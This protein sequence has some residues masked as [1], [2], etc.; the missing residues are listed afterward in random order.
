MRENH[1]ISRQQGLQQDSNMSDNNDYHPDRYDDVD[2]VYRWAA[3]NPYSPLHLQHLRQPVPRDAPRGLGDQFTFRDAFEDLLITGSG[4]ALPDAREVARVK[5]LE[6]SYHG[7]GPVVGSWLGGLVVGLGAGGGT[8]R[9][10]GFGDTGG[11]EVHV[12]TW[13]Q[14]LG[15]LGLWGSFFNL[16]P[17]IRDVNVNARANAMRVW[18]PSRFTA[19]ELMMNPFD[20][21]YYF[22]CRHHAHAGPHRP[23]PFWEELFGGPDDEENE[24]EDGDDRNGRTRDFW[25]DED[26]ER[27]RARRGRLLDPKKLW[28]DAYKTIQ[29][30]VPSFVEKPRRDDAGERR[31]E[32]QDAQVEEDL[33]TP[34]P[35]TPPPNAII[36]RPNNNVTTTT[37]TPLNQQGQDD[38]DDNNTSSNISTTNYPDGK[39]LVVTTKHR[40][41]GNRSETTK[42]S[43]LFDQD[44]N[45][46]AESRETSSSRSW[47]SGSGSNGADGGTGPSASAFLSWKHSHSHTE[48][49]EAGEQN[50]NN[51]DN[52][53]KNG[54]FWE[55]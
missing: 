16:R 51:K 32:G 35:N 44:G 2:D 21:G 36:P 13:V 33:Y 27:E 45:L 38:D 8:P 48:G 6:S 7:P 17:E 39:K 18:R 30:H 46:I 25:G 52:K 34:N 54:W 12:T 43:Q 24:N 40:D 4:A 20:R 19:D 11:P 37:V 50:D 31:E 53:K 55:R 26:E 28:D 15:A 47:R 9:T 22:R 14:H 10:F 41:L 29:N 5:L 1:S 23:R 42:T 49:N 3:H